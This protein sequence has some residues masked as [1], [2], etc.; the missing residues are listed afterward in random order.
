LVFSGNW[1]GICLG[2]GAFGGVGMSEK[3]KPARKITSWFYIG[4]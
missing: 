2:G 4:E 1:L 3:I